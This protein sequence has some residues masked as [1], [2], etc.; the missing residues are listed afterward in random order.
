MEKDKKS[1]TRSAVFE[2]FD[3]VDSIVF[4]VVLMTMLFVFV[5][6][7]VRISGDSMQNTVFND[8][9]VVISNVLY[10]PKRGDVVVVSRDFFNTMQTSIGSEPIIKRVIA[11]E[12]ETVDIDFDEGIVYVNGK[13]LDEPYVKNLTTRKDDVNFPLTVKEGCVFLLGD[14]RAV[15]KDSRDSSIGLVDER[16]ILGKVILRVY[17]FDRIGGVK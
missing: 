5:F 2:V 9:R 15:S 14:N 13:P 6:R 4:A 17:P 8:E 1:E 10:T 11:T 12:G 7:V 16:Y 3:W